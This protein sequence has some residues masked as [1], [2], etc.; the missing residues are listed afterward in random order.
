MRTGYFNFKHLGNREWLNL[1][2]IGVLCIMS[3]LPGVYYF[4]YGYIPK[5]WLNEN[6]LYETVG[7]MACFV[8]GLISL[9]NFRVLRNKKQHLDSLWILL[10]AMGC[11]LLAGE[12]ISW[13]QHFF[14]YDLPDSVLAANFQKEFNL[15]NLKFIQPHNNMLSNIAFKLLAIYLILLPMFLVVFPT[16]E[17]W[18]RGGGFPIPSM[19][20]AVIALL[21]QAMH[22][23]NYKII[24]SSSNLRSSQILEE[25][26]ES[27]FEIC[28]LI[29]AIEYFYLVKK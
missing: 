2:V 28:L 22:R 25:V 14:K 16:I 11:L 9:L 10:F 29:L 24:Y 15:H 13:G 23:I 20:I 19:L 27:M 4:I 26:S 7:A 1:F 17:K 5:F 21:D 6:G 8:A 18:V 3:V 12:E